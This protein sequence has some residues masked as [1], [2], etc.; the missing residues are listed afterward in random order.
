ML[1]FIDV[2]WICP[3]MLS[4]YI[5]YSRPAVRHAM[6]L[7]YMSVVWIVCI[8]VLL[9]TLLIVL[10][11][12]EVYIL[13]IVVSYAHELIICDIYLAFGGIFVVGT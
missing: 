8:P 7:A 9:A 1:Q 11:S 6:C 13:T 5:N 3:V 4:L 2:W 10:S 12:Y